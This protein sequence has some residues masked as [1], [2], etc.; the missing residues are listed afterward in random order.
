M[1]LL[2]MR[3]LRKRGASEGFLDYV[4]ADGVKEQRLWDTSHYIMAVKI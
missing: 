4:E 3:K 1:K 2:F